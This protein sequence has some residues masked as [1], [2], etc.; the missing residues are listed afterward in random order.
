MLSVEQTWEWTAKV[1]HM[2][3]FSMQCQIVS[4]WLYRITLPPAMQESPGSSTSLLILDIFPLVHLSYFGGYIVIQYYVF[5]LH[6][7]MTNEIEHFFIYFN[8]YLDTRFCEVPIPLPTFP[9]GCPHFPVDLGKFFIYSGYRWFVRYMYC[10]H[11]F[12]CEFP[13]LFS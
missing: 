5:N 8:S 11:V 9:L 12:H 2:F 3:S 4:K 13:F 6:S 7:L 10:K 1:I